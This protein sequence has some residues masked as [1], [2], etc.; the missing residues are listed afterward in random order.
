VDNYAKLKQSIEENAKKV[1][2][3]SVQMKELQERDEF[4]SSQKK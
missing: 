3:T 2:E 1:E 4:V